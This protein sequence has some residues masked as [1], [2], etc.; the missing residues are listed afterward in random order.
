MS[1]DVF[2]LKKRNFNL[3]KVFFLLKKNQREKKCLIKFSEYFK[4]SKNYL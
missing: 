3:K 1:G 2:F 4:K